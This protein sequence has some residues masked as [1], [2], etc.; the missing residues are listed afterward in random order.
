MIIQHPEK[1][2]FQSTPPARGATKSPGIIL[3]ISCDFNPR[4]P[5]G[6]RR[7]G[8]ST[9]QVSDKF[10]STPP[11]RGATCWQRTT[12]LT[13]RSPLR[14]Q[15]TPPAR[16]ATMPR[17]YPCRKNTDNFN[18]RPPRGGRRVCLFWLTMISR[19]SIHAP[20][21]GGDGPLYLYPQYPQGFQ[22]TPPA[23]GATLFNTLSRK[24]LPISIHAPR[25]GG[26]R[27][28]AIFSQLLRISIHAP[29]EGGDYNGVNSM[30]FRGRFQ[31]TPPA[32]GATETA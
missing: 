8:F 17:S 18:P 13:P 12:T 32:R 9:P 16:G 10:Q 1:P 31:S 15:S 14:F 25:E 23:R 11:A 3:G 20:R 4:P 6:G 29:R 30:P 2:L 7:T 28:F 22:S 27:G 5:R 19:I 24:P 21:E 26:D